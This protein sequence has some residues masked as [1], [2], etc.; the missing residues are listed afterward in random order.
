MSAYSNRSNLPYCVDINSPP[1]ALNSRSTKYSGSYVSSNSPMPFI[2]AL[3]V[4]SASV[5]PIIMSELVPASMSLLC[6][7]ARL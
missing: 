4:S 5:M 2:V 1:D 3:H 6:I 7:C